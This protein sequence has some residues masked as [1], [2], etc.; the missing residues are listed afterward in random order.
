MEI[1]DIVD[2]NGNPTG[3]TV[4]R[5]IA[6]A[7]GLRH[8][9]A[10]VWLL[11]NRG[12]EIQVL[13][14]KRSLNKDSHPDCYDISSAGHIPA[15]VDYIPSALRELKE[16]L[17]LDVDADELHYCGQRHIFF[18]EAFHHREFVDNQVSNVYY[19]WKDVEL[20]Q[21]T[22]QASEVDDVLWMGLAQ[23]KRAVRENLFEHCIVME[24]LDMLPQEHI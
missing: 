9:T 18:K 15:G 8:R 13:L 1:I 7:Q 4:D 24:E 14:Q 17:G 3:E 5:E 2:E 19:V 6:H 22:L 20:E 23:C 16:E 11:R 12:G 21:L 10:H